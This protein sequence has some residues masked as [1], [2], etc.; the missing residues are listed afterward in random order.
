MNTL[1]AGMVVFFGMHLV[2]LTPLKPM[3]QNLLS[4]SGYRAAFALVS[5]I[6]LGVMLKGF[7]GTRAG[8]ATAN[9]L[10]W[11][12]EWSNQATAVL[13]FAGLVFIAASFHKG[14]IKAKLKSP[15]SIG[16][17][18]W[19]GGHL[20]SNPRLASVLLFGGF[21]AYALLDIVVTAVRNKPVR[22]TPKPL[23][24]LI[25]LVAGALL[26]A[27]FALLFHVYVLN[28]PVL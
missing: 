6:G 14:Y 11:P 22:F 9:Y 8:P 7:A 16:M 10:F 23:H 4:R 20:L 21:F 5:A 26:F 13:V 24:D 18:L 1:I 27:V 12:A 17:A 19:A 15:M 28:L 25:A 3:L 2:P